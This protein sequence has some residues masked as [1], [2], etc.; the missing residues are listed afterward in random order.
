M[1]SSTSKS[2]SNFGDSMANRNRNTGASQAN[3]VGLQ[4]Q[5][6]VKSMGGIVPGTAGLADPAAATKTGPTFMPGAGPG[7]AS[8]LM[9]NGIQSV[10]NHQNVVAQRGKP[11]QSGTPNTSQNVI[12]SNMKNHYNS[13]PQQTVIGNRNGGGPITVQQHAQ[14]MYNQSLS[15]IA[16]ITAA[17]RPGG[18]R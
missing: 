5:A 6:F 4:N 11:S 8:A 2:L 15:G 13:I 10:Q 16:P 7:L 14:D 3:A 18:R 1:G 12:M 9:Q 17:S